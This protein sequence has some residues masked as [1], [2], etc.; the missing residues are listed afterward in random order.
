MYCTVKTFPTALP[1]F[2]ALLEHTRM[3]EPAVYFNFEK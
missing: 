1:Q 2:R 3:Q